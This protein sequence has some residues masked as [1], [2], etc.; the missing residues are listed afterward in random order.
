MDGILENRDLGVGEDG[1]EVASL[2]VDALLVGRVRVATFER[3]VHG[4]SGQGKVLAY[5]LMV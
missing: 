5:M 3:P 1:L 2:A 4:L